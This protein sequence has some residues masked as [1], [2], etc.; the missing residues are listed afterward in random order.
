MPGFTLDTSGTVHAVPGAPAGQGTY[1]PVDLDWCD[2]DAFTQGYISAL[3]ASSYD[4]LPGFMATAN[5]PETDKL[6]THPVGF[7]DLAPET[8]ARIIKDCAAFRDGMA[9]ALGAHF[10]QRPLWP[11]GDERHGLAGRD[12][13]LT[14]N[15]AGAG[16]WDG[17]WPEPYASALTAAAEAAGP[18]EIYLGDDGRIY[19]S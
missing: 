14:R 1:H 8:L 16:F 18:A 5:Q 12:F 13:W 19:Q 4:V 6:R 10:P 2:L 11:E 3:F 15:G 9:S 7:S 17:G